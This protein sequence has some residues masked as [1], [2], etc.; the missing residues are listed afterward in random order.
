MIYLYLI[1]AYLAAPMAFLQRP[2]LDTLTGMLPPES[3]TTSCTGDSKDES[4]GM[5][6]SI[7]YISYC[8][9]TSIYYISHCIVTSIYYIFHCIVTSI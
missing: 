5:T 9:V 2:R 7:Y 3:E 8:I 4:L 1:A 6:I